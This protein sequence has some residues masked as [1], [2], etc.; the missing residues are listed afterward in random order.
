MSVPARLRSALRGLG[1]E[2]APAADSRVLGDPY[3]TCAPTTA[4]A[5]HATPPHPMLLATLGGAGGR[6]RSPDAGRG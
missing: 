3:L 1:V 4:V 5:P 2:S 6:C